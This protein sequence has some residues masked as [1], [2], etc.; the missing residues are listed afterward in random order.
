MKTFDRDMHILIRTF[1]NVLDILKKIG[2]FYNI[3]QFQ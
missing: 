1:C 2:K 3:L